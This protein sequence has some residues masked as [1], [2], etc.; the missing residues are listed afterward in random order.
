MIT[1]ETQTI[2]LIRM[3]AQVREKSENVYYNVHIPQKP[4]HLLHYGPTVPKWLYITM[5]TKIFL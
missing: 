3:Y 2:L 5:S 1:C 4:I